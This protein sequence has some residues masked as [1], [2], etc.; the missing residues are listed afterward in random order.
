[1][2]WFTGY[3]A[4]QAVAS[5]RP[6]LYPRALSEGQFYSPP[7]SFAGKT[8]SPPLSITPLAAGSPRFPSLFPS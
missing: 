8:C 4:A 3:L 6:L 1:M 2:L 5:R 7:E